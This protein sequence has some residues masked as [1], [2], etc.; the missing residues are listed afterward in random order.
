[1]TLGGCVFSL[2][3]LTS[4]KAKQSPLLSRP[5]P[6]KSA[7]GRLAPT[8]FVSR[9]CGQGK[10]QS[11]WLDKYASAIASLTRQ[12]STAAGA[13]SRLRKPVSSNSVPE[14][15]ERRSRTCPLPSSSSNTSV[16]GPF[17]I[18]PSSSPLVQERAS[19][20]HGRL[21]IRYSSVPGARGM[22]GSSAASRIPWRGWSRR[23]TKTVPVQHS[24]PAADR[25]PRKATLCLEGVL[26]IFRGSSGLPFLV[27]ASLAGPSVESE[28][29]ASGRC[30]SSTAGDALGTAARPC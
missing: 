19:P 25:T 2:D 20:E 11:R 14:T 18:A 26:R 6:T 28:T 12:S 10:K 15:R 8:L 27:P 5:N 17:K 30:C 9:L 29:D 7:P 13:F 1:M 3:D 23:S 24:R 22:L 16:T 4:P 21:P